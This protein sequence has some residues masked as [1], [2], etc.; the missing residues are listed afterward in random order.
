MDEAIL[1]WIN[2]SWANPWLDKLFY[3][4]SSK[5]TFALPLGLIIGAY[6]IYG[7]K[8]PGFN[9]FIF[10]ILLIVLSDSLGAALKSWFAQARPCVDLPGI[11]RHVIAGVYPDCGARFDGMPSNHALNF[12]CLSFFLALIL[13]SKPLFFG[14][15]TISVIVALSRIYLGHH[16]P[17]QVVVGILI[18]SIL[19]IVAA[20]LFSRFSPTGITHSH[21]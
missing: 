2:Q 14:L 21:D 6:L 20:Y 12:F 3:F 11:L 10:S 13:R 8:R 17:S 15:L 19:G 18:G 4:A 7:Y 5:T 9:I 16:Y 1:L